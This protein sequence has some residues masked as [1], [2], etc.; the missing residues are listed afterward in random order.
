MNHDQDKVNCKI[1]SERI[2]MLG[3]ERRTDLD[4]E[5]QTQVQRQRQKPG[6]SSLSG[7]QRAHLIQLP[8]PGSCAGTKTA[9]TT[10]SHTGGS[11]CNIIN[12][13]NNINMVEMSKKDQL[14]FLELLTSSGISVAATTKNMNK[15]NQNPIIQTPSQHKT[16]EVNLKD[17][18]CDNNNNAAGQTKIQIPSISKVANIH[19]TVTGTTEGTHTVKGKAAVTR[20]KTVG[21]SSNNSGISNSI[22]NIT[23]N[24]K[25]Q[26]NFKTSVK[27][28]NTM[29]ISSIPTLPII[30]NVPA[31]NIGNIGN[32]NNITN[33]NN[34]N[35]INNISSGS[36]NSIGYG[37]ARGITMPK[38]NQLNGINAATINGIPANINTTIGGTTSTVGQLSGISG[39]NGINGITTSLS[40]MTGISTSGQSVTGGNNNN[41]STS[42][43]PSVSIST[44]TIGN[45]INS[46]N[47]NNLINLNNFNNLNNLNNANLNIDLQ[48]NKSCVSNVNN[49]NLHTLQ[50]ILSGVSSKNLK[51]ITLAK[52]INGIDGIK[53]C[54]P[55]I[56]NVNTNSN[57]NISSIAGPTNS[58]SNNNN[59]NNVASVDIMSYLSSKR[60]SPYNLNINNL[61][62]VNR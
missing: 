25:S 5:T 33:I 14:S 55:M 2:S 45:N 1:K 23:G 9:T 37:P 43:N 41:I 40:P 48:N 62:N 46:I 39:I 56:G 22:N 30:T 4:V 29:T 28:C 15:L 16:K 36:I 61:N 58:N 34:I 21:C 51:I 31:I 42:I 6:Q 20:S 8:Q 47:L 60:F 44:P 19:S 35:G 54:S 12:N 11:N 10:Q 24:D 3:A 52:N 59:V 13:N 27:N 18:T 7:V 57:C 38:M 53:N 49:I 32:L 50:Q 17:N 26:T